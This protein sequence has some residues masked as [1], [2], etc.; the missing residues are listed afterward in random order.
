MRSLP[1]QPSTKSSPSKAKIWS[2]LPLPVIVSASGVP[3]QR[4]PP[5]GHMRGAA[6][7]AAPAASASMSAPIRISFTVL[8]I[9]SVL[10]YPQARHRGWTFLAYCSFSSFN[11]CPRAGLLLLPTVASGVAF[12]RNRT[13]RLRGLL[14]SSSCRLHHR[15]HTTGSTRALLSAHFQSELQFR[16]QGL[17]GS[18]YGSPPSLPAC[19]DRGGA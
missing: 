3:T 4:P 11:I 19:P 8:L 13:N 16:L 14:R 9:S 15:L 5:L 1:P 6:A 10:S 12:L 18:L 2:T 7:S 17:H